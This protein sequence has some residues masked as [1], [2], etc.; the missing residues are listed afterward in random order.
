VA[1]KG[2]TERQG[3]KDSTHGRGREGCRI[4][5]KAWEGT[6]G[7]AQ[8]LL[9]AGSGGRYVGLSGQCRGE[10]ETSVVCKTLK[11][12]ANGYDV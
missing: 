1:V 11:G 12:V 8:Q 4:P 2:P 7:G 10:A 6:R 5:G 9:G 3:S